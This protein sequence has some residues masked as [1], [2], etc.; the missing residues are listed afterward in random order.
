MV[1]GV[2]RWTRYGS[3]LVVATVVWEALVSAT[4]AVD[5]SVN[6]VHGVLRHYDLPDLRKMVGIAGGA[7]GGK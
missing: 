5:Q 3:A 6:T 1:A 7:H 4:E 2:R